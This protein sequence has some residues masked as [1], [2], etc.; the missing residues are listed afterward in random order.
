MD[1][2]K[3]SVDKKIAVLI[4]ADNTSSNFAEAL[5]QE[6]AQYGVASVRRIY[7]DWTRN[8]QGWQDKLLDFALTPIQQFSYTKNK[9]AT[10]MQLII[11]AMDLL[12]SGTFDAFC[13][14]SSDSDFT[15]LAA[16]LRQSGM[17]VYGFGKQTTPKSLTKSCDKFVYFENIVENFEFVENKYETNT[18]D[19]Q[20][21][22]IRRSPFGTWK[23]NNYNNN[24]N[25]YNNYNANN[26]NKPYYQ[27]KKY[28]P[29]EVRGYVYTAITHCS[30]YTGWAN[31][32]FIGHYIKNIAPDFDFRTYGFLSLSDMLKSFNNLQFKMDEKLRMFCRRI[33]FRE[34]A[35][36][37][38]QE[39][40]PKYQ[41]DNGQVSI[42]EIEDL[43][44]SKWNWEEYGFNS[45]MDLL[46]RITNIS[47]IDDKIEIKHNS[48]SSPYSQSYPLTEAKLDDN[49]RNVIYS[50]IQENIDE[51]GWAFVAEVGQTIKYKLPDFNAR[52]YGFLKISELLKT[53]NDLQ[54]KSI[55]LNLYCRPIPIKNLE[56]LFINQIFPK[57]QDCDNVVDIDYIEDIVKNKWNW[58]DYGF[59]SFKELLEKLDII[60]FF[61][62]NLIQLKQESLLTRSPDVSSQE[63][64]LQDNSLQN[65]SSSQ[66]NLFL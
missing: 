10:D 32:G 6:I 3:I 1:D 30:D 27:Q 62:D 40:F 52:N 41:D 12:Y 2:K 19:T 15:P 61:D 14:V 26:N 65:D 48:Y 25:N 13:L 43:V 22:T 47:I 9:D 60:E 21:S 39:I 4:D 53:F 45:F 50:S 66:S 24:Y 31:V 7:G 51:T 18:Y 8:P 28:I 35:D 54:F 29:N 46:N 55:G 59:N 57:Y 34:V 42:Q 56:E 64:S 58:E 49:T 16:R 33:H 63:D 37:L 5:F 11:D 44:K 23:Y 38:Q 17:T 36:L 20:Y